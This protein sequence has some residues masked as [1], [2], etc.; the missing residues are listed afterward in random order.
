[1]HCGCVAP[2]MPPASLTTAVQSAWTWYRWSIAGCGGATELGWLGATSSGPTWHFR[3]A[4][5]HQHRRALV[6]ACGGCQRV[7]SASGREMWA[8]AALLV[9]AGHIRPHG[10]PE[11]L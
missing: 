11:W 8:G 4:R 3:G 6:L 7:V 2:V 9:A 1:M 10:F 5:T